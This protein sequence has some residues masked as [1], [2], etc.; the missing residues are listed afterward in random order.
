MAEPVH[1]PELAQLLFAY[2]AGALDDAQ[3]ARVEAML[4]AEPALRDE[5]RWYEA[6][7]DGMIETLPPPQALPSVERLM[8]RISRKEVSSKDGWLA[9]LKPVAAALIVVQAV[10]I[11]MLLHARGE[12]ERYRSVAP[13]G[14]QGKSVTFVIAFHPD[15]PESKLRAL[16]LKAG[17][18][19]V[20]GP[21][22]MGDYRVAVPA[23]RAQYARQLFEDSGIAE[24]VR[25]E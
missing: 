3:R 25:T 10:A 22:Q 6:V 8:N 20:D 11:G 2:A 14:A 21:K 19:I 17:A 23:N 18:T 4:D 24:Y 1:S 13:A 16:L 9:W 7:C 12:A 15:T 5:L